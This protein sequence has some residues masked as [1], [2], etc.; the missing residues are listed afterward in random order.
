MKKCFLYLAG[1]LVLL[2]YSCTDEQLVEQTGNKLRITGSLAS[3]SRT[4]FV[5]GEGVI[6][7]H[8]NIDDE[9]GLL[10]EKQT[11]LPYKSLEKGKF[12]EFSKLYYSS[13][14]LNPEEDVMVYAY[15]P[16]SNI[17][18]GIDA[19]GLPNTSRYSGQPIE[20]FL[21]A[22]STINNG[23]LN[24]Q[25]KHLFA[26][27][28]II[29]STKEIMERLELEGLDYE[30]LEECELKIY[31][32]ETLSINSY[33]NYKD[34]RVY[35]NLKT[36]EIYASKD[37]ALTKSIYFSC[38]DYMDMSI[39]S[40]Y[41]FI[42]PIL[43]QSEGTEISGDIHA[44]TSVFHRLYG[45]Q[46]IAPKG[47]LQAG[48]VYTWDLTE[49]FKYEE[50]VKLLKSFY[51]KTGGDQW[52]CNDNWFS[53]KPLSEWFGLNEG[54]Y[55]YA[56]NNIERLDLA[57]NNLTGQFPEEV[58]EIMSNVNWG[59]APEFGI[60]LNLNGNNLYG[61]I[62]DAVK[63]HKR[64]NE[65][66]WG[67]VEQNYDTKD[68]LDLTNSNLYVEN[69]RVEDL[70]GD[71]STV[72]YLY[73]IFKQN[74]L[75]Q[76]TGCDF[77]TKE[78]TTIDGVLGNFI[79]GRV[80]QHM[81]YHGKG[82]HTIFFLGN[83][84]TKDEENELKNS[85]HGIYGEVDG[86]TW[87]KGAN[88]NTSQY[89]SDSYFYDSNGQLVY[90]AHHNPTCPGWPDEMLIEKTDRFLR[91]TLGEPE[92]HPEFTAEIYT[93]TDY[94]R[95]GEVV[96]LQAATV[97]KGINLVFLGEAFVDKDMEPGGLYEQTMREA[98]EQFFLY[99]P[100][101]SFRD[102]FNVYA[103]KA[104][105][106][107]STFMEGSNHAINENVSVCFDYAQKIPN[108]GLNPPMVSVIYRDHTWNSATFG[109]SYCI[110]S[111]DGSF[112]SFIIESLGNDGS[113]LMHESGGHGFA[114][115]LD[116]YVEYG[117]EELRLP[118]DRKNSL[119]YNWTNYG[120]G[121]NVDWRNDVSTVKWSHFLN[122][123]RYA[124]EGLG[125]YEGAYLY[126]YG[127]YRPSEN[128]MM[129][130]NDSPFNAPSREQI[131][132]RIMQR[133]EGKSWTYDYEEFVKYDE[134]N[135]KSATRA[136][137]RPL[138]EAEKKEYAKKHCPPTFIKGTWRDAMKNG[139][140]N[141]VIPLR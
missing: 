130:Y 59:M 21:Y 117:N 89:R 86:I 77:S 65:L 92:E 37:W 20:P 128:S 124:D 78:K 103:V 81:D 29:I 70:F 57:N 105:S 6:E 79:D 27:L 82:L 28:K 26:Y 102:R 114:G 137:V 22:Q 139:K 94:S 55:H 8:W 68:E 23:E 96:S 75:T 14:E 99:E 49:P 34:F 135:R 129:R 32:T 140:S 42:L 125:L 5:E 83:T 69:V 115:L 127:A 87:L 110:T 7:T 48:H 33:A 85:L 13:E 71:E 19:I 25:F 58:A 18:E 39:D 72:Q 24:F 45:T 15:Y 62:P 141:T 116:E 10:T 118:E 112:A 74:K 31:S 131:Y 122:D 84:G 90:V 47:G 64:W 56:S 4:T 95:D 60:P 40:T 136:A 1:L 17:S 134:I 11:N 111:T 16:Y 113:V 138:S 121:A 73:D 100:Y 52:I 53:G 76:I 43:P 119:E 80:N 107:N 38:K 67:C 109:R 66:G 98:M 132:K 50:N 104:V 108:A 61:P 101:K 36:N 41:T 63:N 133:S 120:R 51:D 123:D 3:D 35:Y 54:G 126:G 44:K 2:A 12:T 91:S 9:I 97:G 46:K 93:S 30:S 88:N 106:P